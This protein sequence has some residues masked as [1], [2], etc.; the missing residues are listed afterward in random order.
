MAL[1]TVLLALL[2]LTCSRLLKILKKQIFLVEVQRRYGCVVLFRRFYQQILQ[3]LTTEGVAVPIST[4]SASSAT[5]P[6]SISLDKGTVD[7]LFQSIGNPAKLGTATLE[8]LR[9]TMRIFALVSK[10]SQNKLA[11]VSSDADR[12]KLLDIILNT[13][14]LSDFE[15]RRC[16]ATL[17]SNMA[18]VESIRSELVSKLAG[19]MFQLLEN[20]D[21][22]A[23]AGFTSSSLIGTEIHRQIAQALVLLTQTHAVDVIRQPNSLHYLEILNKQK[24]APDDLFRESVQTTLQQLTCS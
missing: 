18:S 5:P 17:L 11:L 22:S 16:G 7:A 19:C 14:Q 24:V 10:T 23:V 20:A 8:N 13:L 9:E 15:V 12:S 1:M 4:S 6:S 2:K 21:V 3:A